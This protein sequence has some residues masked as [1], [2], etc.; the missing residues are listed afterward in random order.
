VPNLEEISARAAPYLEPIPGPSPAGAPA[1]FDPEYQ[2]AANE[3]AKLDAPAGGAVNWKV[4]AESAG[5]VLRGKS[6]DLVIASYL[7]RAL[8]G[9]H[10]LGG[11]A[12]G[13]A[14]LSGLLDRYWET[15]QPDAKRVRGRANAVQWFL[16]RSGP[17]LEAAAREAPPRETVEQ[18]DAAARRLEEIARAR[19]ADATP[20]FGP[21]L[22]A[23]DRLKLAAPA[24]APAE[25]AAVAP[26]PPPQ[27]A[28]LPPSAAPAA[29]S[30]PAPG[31]DGIGPFLEKVGEALVD[32]ARQ[33]RAASD[34]D[35]VAYRTL[36]AGLWLHLTSAPVGRGGRT[37]VPPPPEPLR[38]RVAQLARN[39][40]WAP[41]LDE[42]ESALPS[43]RFA[44]DLHRASWEALR[45]LGAS[46][47]AARAAV[48]VET[49]SL[50]GRM[51]ELTSLAFS[52]GTPFADPQTRSWI[53]EVAVPPQAGAAA[54]AAGAEDA[55]ARL[56][57]PLEAL[58]AGRTAEALAAIGAAVA[59]APSG[60]DRFVL[61]LAVARACARAGLT[62]LAKGTYEELDR[63]VRA[64]ELEVWEPRL[65]VE[66]LK[67][68][69]SSVQALGKDPRATCPDL[70]DH[71]QR[72]C[73][74]DPAA[75]HEVWP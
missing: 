28:P 4:V 46:H 17:L 1:R 22:E 38:S 53:Q 67:G 63:E 49:R 62:A 33:L 54:P 69:I 9:T 18:L 20:A 15:M 12:T 2:A 23:L 58:A 66:A 8:A 40:Q 50:L 72:L 43:S 11:L 51:P 57:G 39:G 6:K 71:Y 31:A 68:L 60:R 73:G 26:P 74:I 70:H 7:A 44:L 56:A 61:R 13:T 24:P 19:L 21:L 16:D 29:P 25:P 42:A 10:G 35:P 52:D 41:L 55:A 30:L 65:A 75:A 27:A 3:V 47:A 64:H 34:A 45:G 59:S 14:V 37:S 36:R 32:A 5:A 48:E